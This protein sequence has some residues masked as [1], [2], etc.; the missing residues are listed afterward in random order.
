MKDRP[1]SG[2]RDAPRSTQCIVTA[3]ACLLFSLSSVVNLGARIVDP[4][5]WMSI[6]PV[7]AAKLCCRKPSHFKEQKRAGDSR[8]NPRMI[9]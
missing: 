8:V 3:N 2:E 1:D 7:R 9:F 4:F 5:Q 6:L